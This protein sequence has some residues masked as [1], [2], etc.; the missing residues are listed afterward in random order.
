MD[1]AE[2]WSEQP[3]RRSILVRLFF[4]SCALIVVPS[5]L[6][7]AAFFR[8]IPGRMEAQARGNADFYAGQAAAAV[9]NS[10]GLARD[11]AYSA[12]ADADLRA[13]M[14][15]PSVYL[16]VAG[17][18][19]LLQVVGGVAA[20]Q[21]TW[22]ESGL[23]SVYLFRDDGQFAFY[24]P[25]G[26]Y[27]Q[28][29]RRMRQVRSL[30]E[31]LSSPQTLF[32]L[33]W[34]S[35]DTVYFL[36]DYRNISNLQVLGKLVIEIDVDR[37]VSADDLTSLYPGACL[38]LTSAEGRLLYSEGESAAELLERADPSSAYVQAPAGGGLGRYYHIGQ[39]VDGTDLHLQFFIPLSSIY[40]TTW[41]GIWIF[42]ALC[43]LIVLLAM[44]AALMAYRLM[45]RFAAGMTGA[46]RRMAESEYT[47]RMPSSGYRELADLEA[48]FNQ[49]ADNLEASFQDA[50]QKGV[51]LQESESRLLA[52]QINPHFIF[53][54]L[55]TINMRCAGAGLKDISRMVTNLAS[56]LRGNIGAGSSQKVPFE[57]ELRYVHYYLDLQRE[58]FGENLVYSVEYED[59]EL[60]H[61]LVPRLTIQPLVENAIVHG[62]EPRRGLGCVS[63]R[64]WEEAQSICVRVEDN[65]VG[66]DPASLDLSGEAADTGSHNHIALPNVLRRLHLL[67]GDRADLK[68]TSAPGKGTQVMLIL[69]IDETRG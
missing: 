30:G 64:L 35:S 11:V 59:E 15:D 55:E 60:L 10:V 1:M 48:A 4:L 5:L 58:R 9:S 24:S 53:N 54:V 39:P 13:A 28:E 51:R 16:A 17:R 19:A 52:A 47:A 18:D 23:N 44:G 61:Y 34:V 69:P 67:Y 29:Q 27:A 21:S 42:S 2:K 26:S 50:Y 25:R 6:T 3:R 43:V 31:D 45:R 36:L 66:F 37:M 68:I 49:M 41:E 63:L 56:L 32:T 20:Y 38:A 12:L 65:G 33:P 8:I 14:L 62:L 22:S 57:Q 46:L 40:G 7:L